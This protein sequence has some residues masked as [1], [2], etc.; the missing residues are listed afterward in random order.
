[1]SKKAR[2]REFAKAIGATLVLFALL[3]SVLR[4]AYV[5]RNARVASIPLPYAMGHDYGPLPPWLDALRILEPDEALIWRNRPNIRRSYIDIFTPAHTEAER[6]SPLRRF[7]PALP[8]ALDGTPVWEISLNSEGFR[9]GAFPEAKASSVFRIICLGD[10]WTFGANVGQ[11]RAYPQRLRTLLRREF[12][13]ANF[14]VLNLGVLGYSSFQGL[15]LLKRRA[16]GLDPDLV[17][18][19]FGMNDASVAGYRD[20]DM[21]GH[22]ETLSWAKMLAG[23]LERAES[24]RLLRYLALVLKHRPQSVGD[25][26]KANAE[27]AGKADERVEYE[28]LEAWTRVS[29]KD[30]EKNIRD[31]IALARRRRAGVILLYN[32]LW[33]NSPYRAVLERIARTE[34]VSL[35]DSSALIAAARRALE[36]ELERKLDLRPARA[37]RAPAKQEVEVIFRVYLGDR[38]GAKAISIVGAHPALGDLVPN[39]VAMHDDGTHGDQR[40]GDGVWSFTATF[41]PGTRVFYVYTNGGEEGRWEGL[42]VPEIRSFTVE[43]GTHEGRVYRPIESFGK[44]PMQAD[45]WHT[46]AAGYDLIARALLEKLIH[47]ERVRRYLG[48]VPPSVTTLAERR[49]GG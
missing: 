27:A 28:K 33:G 35:V 44:I 38:P 34:G 30:Y 6:T 25:H 20:K 14:E 7:F 36:G 31:M 15:E 46:D 21:P 10:S 5:V 32:E 19:G 39:R 24:Y 49:Q 17:V 3:E 12:P 2:S 40:A 45:S 1:M 42:D 29:P 11:E 22:K 37:A 43:A 26:L 47:D 8:A 4:L 13:G 18:I 23:A 48:R 9:D 41:P 16:I